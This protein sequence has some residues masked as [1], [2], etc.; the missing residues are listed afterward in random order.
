M[1]LWNY[2]GINIELRKMEGYVSYFQE[3]LFMNIVV[4]LYGFSNWAKDIIILDRFNQIRAVF[5]P[6]AEKK[7]NI[8]VTSTT[9]FDTSF[10]DSMKQ[11]EVCSTLVQTILLEKELCK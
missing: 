2:A 7:T 3:P 4:K 5:H 11:L 6:E 8:L 9:N 1:F 10:V